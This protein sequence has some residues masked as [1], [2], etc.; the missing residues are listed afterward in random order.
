MAWH[1]PKWI[2][3]SAMQ[4]ELRILTYPTEIFRKFRRSSSTTF[5]LSKKTK[6]LSY[7]HQHDDRPPNEMVVLIRFCTSVVRSFETR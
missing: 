3:A 1:P 6:I 2:A 7:Q 4:H 5:R